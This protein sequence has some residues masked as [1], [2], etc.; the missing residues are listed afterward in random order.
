MSGALGPANDRGTITPLPWAT[1]PMALV[2]LLYERAK[3][4]VMNGGHNDDLKTAYYRK[5]SIRFGLL[6]EQE[7]IYEE[8]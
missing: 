5:V 1:P 4:G 2:H 3:L 6:L 8:S 7:G